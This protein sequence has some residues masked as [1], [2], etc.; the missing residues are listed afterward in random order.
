MLGQ[1]ITGTCTVTADS[2]ACEA[3][4]DGKYATNA[5]TAAAPDPCTEVSTNCSA[6]DPP[7]AFLANEAWDPTKD[8]RPCG[9]CADALGITDVEA[10]GYQ[11]V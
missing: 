4:P 10:A 1:R 6:L 7:R 3:C 8:D 9:G 11:I 5:P 2:S